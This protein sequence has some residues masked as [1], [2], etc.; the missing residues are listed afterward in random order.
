MNK[1]EDLLEGESTMQIELLHDFIVL[2][3]ELNFRSAAKALFTTPSTLSK[4]IATLEAH[5]GVRLF[6]RD[7]TG[8]SLTNKGAMLLEG[9]Q[10][11]WSDYERTFDLVNNEQ[12]SATLYVSG[13]LDNPED[14]PLVSQAIARFKSSTGLSPH[15]LPTKSLFPI[16]QVS[17]LESGDSDCAIFYLDEETYRKLDIADAIEFHPV[18]IIPFDALMAKD[19]PLAGKDILSLPDFE[20]QSLIQ[21]VGPRLTPSWIQLKSQLD[22]ANVHYTTTLF[23][24]STPYDYF[25]L[26]PE[27]NL[28][29]LPREY[30]EN[31]HG[32]HA[33]CV[34]VPVDNDAL[35]LKLAALVR[36]GPKRDNALVFLKAVSACMEEAYA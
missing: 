21:L 34:R 12:A 14:Y 23:P 9:A 18:G 33:S 32:G 29:L 17:L 10:K 11:V 1:G 20:G 35:S 36:K 25:N 5:Y 26:N 16:D 31:R 27:G 13:T 4:H 24:A 28:F 22:G 15:L 3:E 6:N 19:H 30:G 2:S 7:K 8:V